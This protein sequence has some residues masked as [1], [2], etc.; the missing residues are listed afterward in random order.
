[1]AK[2]KSDKP[3]PKMLKYLDLLMNMDVVENEEDWDTIEDMDTLESEEFDKKE[4]PI[5]GDEDES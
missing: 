5:E 3:D 4:I 2:K 1:M